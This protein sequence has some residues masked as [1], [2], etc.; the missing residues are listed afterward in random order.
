MPARAVLTDWL[1]LERL[2]RA[3]LAFTFPVDGGHPDLVGG[4]GLQALDD[5]LGRACWRQS[6]V[7]KMFLCL[8]TFLLFVLFFYVFTQ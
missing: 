4:L 6:R 3:A 5:N 2:G 8:R 7:N 1:G